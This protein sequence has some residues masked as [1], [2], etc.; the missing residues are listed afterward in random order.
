MREQHL[1]I[2]YIM[3]GHNVCFYMNLHKKKTFSLFF[4][5]YDVSKDFSERVVGNIDYI[6]TADFGQN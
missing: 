2:N 5:T 3:S 4:S 1:D 6:P